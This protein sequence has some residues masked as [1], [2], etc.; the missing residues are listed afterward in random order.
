MS[1]PRIALDCTFSERLRR[2]KSSGRAK[3]DEIAGLIRIL[4]WKRL[5]GDE[6]PR[7][8]AQLDWGAAAADGTARPLGDAQERARATKAP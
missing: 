4:G 5:N 7:L 6:G 3:S 1:P 2:A 8:E